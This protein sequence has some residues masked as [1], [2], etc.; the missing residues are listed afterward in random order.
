MSN[1]ANNY[2][3]IVVGGGFGGIYQVYKLRELGF[4]VKAFERGAGLGG[5]WRQNVYP[6]A[7]V[8][9]D[10]PVYQLWI[11][12]VYE[13][14]DFEKRFPDWREIQKYF[15]HVDK[16][17][18]ISQHYDYNTWVTE[19]SFD[20]NTGKWTVTTTGD[21]AGTYTAK[22]L[23]LCTGFASKSYTPDFKGLDKFKGTMHHTSEWP[24]EQVDFKGKRVAVV[25]TGASGV[26]VIQ[27]VGPHVESLTVYQRTPNL[28][29][30]MVQTD[31]DKAYENK[32]KENYDKVFE[33]TLVVSTGGFEFGFDTRSCLEVTPEEREAHF[34]ECFRKG[35]FN[36]WVA[37]FHD[38]WTNQE[39]DKHAYDFWRKTVLARLTR[40]EMRELLAP[41]KSPVTWS[42]KRPCLEQTYYEVYNQP[43]VDIVNLRKEPIIEFTEKG[44]RTADHGELEFDIIVLA[45]GFDAVTGGLTQINVRGSKG[46]TL[47]EKWSNGVYTYLGVSA[48][49]FPNM[50][51]MYGPQGPTAFSNG[52]TC[53]QVQANWITDAIVYAEKNNLKAISPSVEAEQ[54]YR[55]HVNAI[56]DATLV[57]Q[58]KSWYTGG[59]IP[60]KKLEALNYLG[61]IPNYIKEIDQEAN[62]HYDN[63]IKVQ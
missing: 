50:F 25:G 29:I 51:F 49:D 53:A 59:N 32:R 24:V 58:T 3:A 2:D 23:L 21:G 15:S 37:N 28:A 13:D 18:N 19:A 57:G 34:K 22:Y 38:I 9:S 6:G 46:E 7:R 11:K 5:V 16:K 56:Q 41:E 61:G 47:K 45:T 33:N 40:P 26:Q 14:F 43:N 52:P 35:G 12:D 42:G 44:I 10:V 4:N 54:K 55:H 63:F 30:P 39:A 17:L 60:G 48:A 1:S 31:N 36:F 20:D 8:D 62:I 27:E